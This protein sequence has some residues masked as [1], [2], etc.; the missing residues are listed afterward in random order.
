[1]KLLVLFLL[2]PLMLCADIK[3]FRVDLSIDKTV[4]SMGDMVLL[5]ASL[6][7][8]E[9]YQVDIPSLIEQTLWTANPS[10]PKF[11]LRQSAVSSD[12]KILELALEPIEEGTLYLTFL[13][14]KFTPTDQ[15]K[16]DKA[17]SIPSPLIK[18]EVGKAPVTGP[19][20]LAPLHPL[21]PELPLK[22]T[23]RNLQA[24]M[25]DPHVKAAEAKRNRTIISKHSFPWFGFFLMIFFIIAWMGIQKYLQYLKEARKAKLEADSA[26]ILAEQSLQLLKSQNLIQEKKYKEYFSGLID[27]VQT[28][29]ERRYR[30]LWNHYTTTEVSQ[31]TS[32]S[33]SE[34]ILKNKFLPLLNIADR[35]KFA[36]YIP[37]EEEN[38][39][40]LNRAEEIIK[41]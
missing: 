35:V 2:F 34:I 25:D 23:R 16:E 36:G 37:T 30:L 27:I 24:L 39:Q 3:D 5:K 26:K 20:I 1:M 11:V 17:V 9:G 6:Q 32:T 40:A 29:L 22:L 31:F 15:S 4:M 18:L 28:Y 13:N 12:K 14:V 8:P 41:T 10:A 7:Y 33:S 38:E 21:E 19:L